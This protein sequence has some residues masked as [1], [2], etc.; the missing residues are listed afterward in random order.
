MKNILL[1]TAVAL[2]A[3]V[4]VMAFSFD[5]PKKGSNGGCAQTFGTLK[6]DGSYISYAKGDDGQSVCVR[7]ADSL[8]VW[9]AEKGSTGHGGNGASTDKQEPYI[10]TKDGSYYVFNFG[11]RVFKVFQKDLEGLPISGYSSNWS[12]LVNVT[13]GDFT[14]R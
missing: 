10:I 4:P 11:D 7:H 14:V 1:A 6:G 13:S 2:I 9:D 5:V 8:Y 12:N 3:A